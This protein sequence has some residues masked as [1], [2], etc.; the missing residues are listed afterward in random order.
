MVVSGWPFPSAAA[1]KEMWPEW[2]SSQSGFIQTGGRQPAPCPLHRRSF[3]I[4]RSMASDAKWTTNAHP[5]AVT[6][7]IPLKKSR[8][9]P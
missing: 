8:Q 4:F 6:L 7:Y 3:A 9:W 1:G 2:K 5:K